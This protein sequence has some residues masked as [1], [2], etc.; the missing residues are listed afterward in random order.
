MI[1]PDPLQWGIRDPGTALVNFQGISILWAGS[2][3]CAE[4]VG[5]DFVPWGAPVPPSWC[6]ENKRGQTHGLLYTAFSLLSWLVWYILASASYRG[7]ATAMAFG[8]VGGHRGRFLPS[9]RH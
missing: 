7:G 3:D 6:R 1:R 2:E 9:P 8:Q 5:R 4:G